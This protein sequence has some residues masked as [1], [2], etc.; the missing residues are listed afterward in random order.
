MWDLIVLVPD[1]CLPFYFA[2][3]LAFIR[4]N[5]TRSCKLLFNFIS[6]FFVIFLTS[7]YSLHLILL[8]TLYFA[9]HAFCS[10]NC[11]FFV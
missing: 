4:I 8:A 5:Q 10:L 1:H 2:K 7:E 11:F 9:S 3:A 6:Q